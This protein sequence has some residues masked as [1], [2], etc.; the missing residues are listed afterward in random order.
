MPP[1]AFGPD[2]ETMTARAISPQP[3]PPVPAGPHALP[4]LCS[5]RV[6]FTVVVCAELV[7]FVL[8]LALP[9]G[10]E[11]RWVT[12]A[13]LSLFV[14]L[15]ALCCAALL[16]AARAH[17]ERLGETVAGFAAWGLVMAVTAALSVAA[18][19]VARE[20]GIAGVLAGVGRTEFVMR[21][22]AVAGILAAVVLRY[23]YLQARA[24]R[25]AEAQ[26][27]AR[28]EA[29]QARIRPHFLFNAL[30]TIAALARTRP[31]VA[32]EMAEDL[33]E[34]IRG[35]LAEGVQPATLA[36][37]LELAERYLRMEALRLGDRLR[38]ELECAEGAGDLL[39]PHLTLQPLV[40]NA[41]YHGIEPSPDGGAVRVGA[42][43]DGD[44]V[45]IEVS[46]PLPPEGG[47]RRGGH[48]MALA[49]INERLRLLHGGR[50]RVEARED[51]GIYRVRLRVPLRPGEAA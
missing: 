35:S 6:V 37:E 41:V 34:L 17:L 26:S 50:A 44:A 12:L 47:P 45:S 7:A 9:G 15:I 38:Y 31:A 23:L 21:S 36:A 29:L 30:N 43:R 33:A 8:T 3:D 11:G 46:N 39:L 42:A 49:N 48:H 32:E 20:A 40:E 28:Y 51:G 27:R 16:C 13:L 10:E 22:V 5:V 24:R 1:Y 19:A 18:I 4:D 25:T 14:Q 2:P